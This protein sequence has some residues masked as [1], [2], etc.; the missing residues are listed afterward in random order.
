METRPDIVAFAKSVSVGS[1]SLSQY[2]FPVMECLTS[3]ARA[4]GRDL[5]PYAADILRTCLHLIHEVMTFH[6]KLQSEENPDDLPD[7][8]SKDFVMCALDVI[9]GLI[10]GLE[11][12]FAPVTLLSPG[13]EELQAIIVQQLIRC[14]CDTDSSGRHILDDF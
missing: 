8:P 6:E 1:F 5:T 13:N 3:V 2:A 12:D 7:P 4:A 14:L 11:Q 10:D 9:G